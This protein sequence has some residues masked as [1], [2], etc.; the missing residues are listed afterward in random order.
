MGERL[1]GGDLH[2]VLPEGQE[3][4]R[5]GHCYLHGRAVPG[6]NRWVVSK[7]HCKCTTH[8]RAHVK[9]KGQG[10]SRYGLANP[11][12][13]KPLQ[14]DADN[15]SAKPHGAR[16]PEEA[17]GRLRLGRA[18]EE[19]TGTR[20]KSFYGLWCIDGLTGNCLS[21]PSTLRPCIE[22]MFSSAKEPTTTMTP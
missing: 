19:A 14:G 7:G 1:P 21:T 11:W 9:L 8:A 17:H 16:R 4:Q 10:V 5:A 12:S 20:G 22:N 13:P 18:A 2:G 6:H 3:A 15:M